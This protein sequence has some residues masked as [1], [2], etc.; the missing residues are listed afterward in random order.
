[1]LN[2]SERCSMKTAVEEMMIWYEM[3]RLQERYVSLIDTDRLEEWPDLMLHMR[4]FGE[5]SMRPLPLA[6]R[7]SLRSGSAW[8][9]TWP[10]Q[11]GSTTDRLHSCAFQ[12]PWRNAPPTEIAGGILQRA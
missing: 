4:G 1:M 10:K 5:K 11:P 2:D 7:S 9:G 12:P 6:P 3:H 8:R